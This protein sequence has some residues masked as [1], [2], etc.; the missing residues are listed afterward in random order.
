MDRLKL[1]DARHEAYL[2]ARA[3]NFQSEE[4]TKAWRKAN[5]AYTRAK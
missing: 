5:T 3:S 2:A 4:L 1:M